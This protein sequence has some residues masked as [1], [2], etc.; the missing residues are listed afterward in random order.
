M[1]H[2]LAGSKCACD[3]W[4]T[5]FAPST[6]PEF[7]LNVTPRDGLW[8]SNRP[9]LDCCESRLVANASVDVD[10]GHELCGPETFPISGR[11]QN[12]RR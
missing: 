2:D 1:K 7:D 5:K 10:G 6:A 4:L 12:H 8:L 9:S 3:V 11:M